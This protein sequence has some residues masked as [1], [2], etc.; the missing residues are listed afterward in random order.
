MVNKRVSVIAALVAMGLVFG[1]ANIDS[2][3]YSVQGKDVDVVDVVYNEVPMS[4][5]ATGEVTILRRIDNSDNKYFP[6]IIEQ[7]TYNSCA[8]W[9]MTYYQTSYEFNR[10]E[11]KDGSLLENQLS[12]VFTYNLT[13]NGKNEG[14]YFTDVAK[15][16]KDVGSVSMAQLPA[17]TTNGDMPIGDISA[18]ANIWREAHKNRIEECVQV[19]DGDADRMGNATPI[20]SPDDEDL[21]EIK[22]A[23]CEGRILTA[24][25]P[26]NKWK[27]KTIEEHAEVPANS[28]YVGQQIMTLCDREGY[29]GHRIT[30]VGY[31]DDIWVDIN[32]NSIVDEGEKGAF[33]IA[34]TRGTEYGN[35]GYMWVSYDTLNIISSVYSNSAIDLGFENREPSL[36]DICYVTVQA[37]KKA[38]PVTLEFEATTS[39]AKA[40]SVVVTATE[41]EGNRN[42]SVY[43]V[44]PFRTS[45]EIGLG[46]VG[47]D[48][49]NNTTTG[50]F[51]IAI[52]NLFKDISVEDLDKY[53]WNVKVSNMANNMPL[54]YSN[55][56]L[57]DE[58]LNTLYAAD[59]AS[60]EITG[61]KF[62][63]LNKR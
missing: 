15:V 60:Y 41:K 19:F 40:M 4:A 30:I 55:L 6:P 42:L 48:G 31:N 3:A 9:A 39:S 7:G 18:D 63:K 10:A 52:D 49:T 23:L 2:K 29:K 53:E 61:E 5:E 43:K 20:T 50:S 57:V 24:S 26:G 25:T 59:E 46:E 33:K 38:S 16:L 28:E 8:S 1:A 22:K 27:Y 21:L 13:N 37:D 34:N 35:D 12:P 17:D 14:T 11:D 32:E 58:N 47:F 56:K 36:I 54:T 44:T 62:I 51:S 45:V